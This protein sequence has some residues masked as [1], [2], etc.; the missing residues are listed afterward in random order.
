MM[1]K[2]INMKTTAICF[3]YIACVVAILSMFSCTNKNKQDI[4][5]QGI[6]DTSNT[7]YST[8]ISPII[9]TS[10]NTQSGCHG[11]AS[12]G[13]VSLESYQDVKDRVTDI[14]NRVNSG[15]MPKNNSKLDDCSISKIESWVNKGAQNN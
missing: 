14:V 3:T 4:L 1:F 7:K 11:G 5:N 9:T 13:S 2:Q 15:N 10:C 8:V 6:C 12:L